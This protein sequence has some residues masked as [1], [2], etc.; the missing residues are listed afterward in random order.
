[1]SLITLFTSIWIYQKK[2]KTFCVIIYLEF[3]RLKILPNTPL[4]GV[5]NTKN[6]FNLMKHLKMSYK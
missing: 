4:K 3:M 5:L 6:I 2:G 1:M